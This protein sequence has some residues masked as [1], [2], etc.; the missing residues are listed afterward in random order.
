MQRLL[1][2][3]QQPSLEELRKK[4]LI[5]VPDVSAITQGQNSFWR[6]APG[7]SSGSPLAF[8]PN[9]LANYGCHPTTLGPGNRR[10]SAEFFGLAP[11][12]VTEA[13]DGLERDGMVRRVPM[14]MLAQGAAMPSLSLEMLRVATGTDTML[15]K[16]DRAGVR[17][18]AVRGFEIPTDRNAQLWMYFAKRDPSLYVSAVDVLD[19][20]ADPAQVA[21]KLVLVGTSSVG[22]LDL[23][24]TPVDPSLPG[25]E[26]HAQLLE[27]ALTRNVLARPNYAIGAELCAAVLLGMLVM[28][29]LSFAAGMFCMDF[30]NRRRHGGF[31]L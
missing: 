15:V 29:G 28:L 8:G 19:G 14:L 25:V 24:T 12:T 17:S 1:Q 20:T 9:L 5:A 23:K 13:L 10:L 2:A 21:R 16:T 4:W 26:V 27:S 11:R 22:L 3:Q 30:L 6:G 7:T 31:R 18:V